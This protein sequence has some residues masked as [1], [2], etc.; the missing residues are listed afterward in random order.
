MIVPCS[1]CAQKNRIPAERVTQTAKCG[2]CG[3]EVSATGRP[4]LI[5]GADF[6]DL[7]ENSPIPVLVDF[8]APW[9]GPCKMVAPE[10]EKLAMRKQGEVVV[11]KLNTDEHPAIA[12]R[13]GVRGI[14]MFALYSGGERVKTQTGYMSAQQLAQNFGL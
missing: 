3:A 4:V 2:K 8:W 11:A 6:H 12:Q 5:S 10:L 9:C 7:V 14:P 13:E 1:S